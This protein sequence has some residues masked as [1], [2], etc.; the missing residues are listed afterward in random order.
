[1]E[2]TEPPLV[3]LG[4]NN[5]SIQAVWLLTIPGNP[6]YAAALKGVRL[7]VTFLNEKH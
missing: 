4:S 1:M 7:N 5:H 6:G 3:T 2:G